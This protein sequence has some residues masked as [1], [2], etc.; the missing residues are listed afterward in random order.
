MPRINA[1]T[2]AVLE[3]TPCT[4]S[5][6]QRCGTAGGTAARDTQTSPHLQMGQCIEHRSD[7][8]RLDDRRAGVEHPLER[9][10]EEVL[11][12]ATESQLH[13]AQH[14]VESTIGP[15][16]T[17]V[18]APATAALT[19]THTWWSAGC[20]VSQHLTMRATSTS[21]SERKIMP[22]RE[23]VAGDAN[24]RSCVSNRKLMLEPNEIRSPL[25]IVSRWLSSSTE[26]S[27]SIH[28]GSTSPSHTIHD[29]TCKDGQGKEKPVKLNAEQNLRDS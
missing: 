9:L 18:H 29:R 19:R 8:R 14:T 24:R 21:S 4:D 15:A 28:S 13:T 22:M 1:H 7:H 2:K 6:P 11:H 3:V 23:M 17:S 10:V 27:D 20:C 5:T 25:G 16:L 26:F 12:P